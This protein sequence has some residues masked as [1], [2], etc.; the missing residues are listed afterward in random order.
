MAVLVIQYI[1]CLLPITAVSA[2]IHVPSQQISEVRGHLRYA[3]GTQN[4]NT[5]FQKSVYLGKLQFGNLLLHVSLLKNND[6][7]CLTSETLVLSRCQK[8]STGGKDHLNSH[9]LFIHMHISTG[10]RPPQTGSIGMSAPPF[11]LEH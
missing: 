2:M 8:H 1:Q 6:H 3:N 11:A 5:P 4:E 7:A 10:I 9:W